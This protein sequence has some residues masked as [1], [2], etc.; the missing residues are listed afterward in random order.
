MTNIESSDIQFHSLSIVDRNGRLFWKG[1]ELYRAVGSKNSYLYARLFEQGV[2][3]Q[4]IKKNLLVETE[5]TDYCLHDYEM[6]LHHRSIPFISY[7]YEWSDTMFKDATLL[8]VDF[9]IELNKY[10]LTSADANSLNILFDGFRPVFID[11]C[12]I[13]PSNEKPLWPGKTY[14]QFKCTFVD[15]LK[16]MAQGQARVARAVMRDSYYVSTRELELQHSIFNLA[17]IQKRNRLGFRDHLLQL[18][19]QKTPQ[20]VRPLLKKTFSSLQ[21]HKALS[22]ADSRATFLTGMRERIA[23]IE[24][25]EMSVQDKAC[26]DNTFTSLTVSDQWV[27]KQK[28]IHNILVEYKPETFLDVDSDRGWYSQLAAINNCK[29]VAFDDNE[30]C[31]RK[32]YSDAKNKKLYIVP[33]LIDFTSPQFDLCNDLFVS[34]NE[35]LSCEMVM[36]LTLTQH[37]LLKRRLTIKKV[38][39][40]LSDLSTR[41]VLLEFIPPEQLRDFIPLHNQPALEAWKNGSCY[42][43]NEFMKVLEDV[44]V[45]VNQLATYGKGKTLL[46][47]R[48]ADKN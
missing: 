21:K 37:L 8:H 11:F 10:D 41:W 35:R 15:F 42:S 28:H 40:R 48:K 30:A 23:Q 18:A 19:R 29:V 22:Q 5:I 33:L 7:P 6:V 13:T 1:S 4:L 3:R 24:L 26:L 16:I 44:F 36:C 27:E 39:M 47:C 20:L 25:P 2:V 14:D 31:V 17:T 34:I 45:N 9:L 12:S 38:L 43:F 32:L 46:L